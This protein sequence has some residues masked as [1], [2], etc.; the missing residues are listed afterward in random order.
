MWIQATRDI[1]ESTHGRDMEGLPF[2]SADPV[3][4]KQHSF[5][6]HL[7][8]SFHSICSI[9]FLIPAASKRCCIL[10]Q[11]LE[12]QC[13]TRSLHP[14][15]TLIAPS[16]H[17]RCVL[18]TKSTESK[19]QLSHLTLGYPGWPDW[20][21]WMCQRS[22]RHFPWT[23]THLGPSYKIRQDSKIKRHGHS[24]DKQR[25]VFHWNDEMIM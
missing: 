10:N 11:T 20:L 3:S 7:F 15:C 24:C 17:L 21:G 12:M 6:W 19:D 13:T 9:L 18:E 14:H 23:R 8:I 2:V 4:S 16:L 22:R 1:L 5:G 25:E